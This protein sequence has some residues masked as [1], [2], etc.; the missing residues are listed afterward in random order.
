MNWVQWRFSLAFRLLHR[1]PYIPFGQ[2]ILGFGI[3]G[4]RQL[5]R[6]RRVVR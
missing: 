5:F 4:I 1:Y 3:G 2:Y 6:M